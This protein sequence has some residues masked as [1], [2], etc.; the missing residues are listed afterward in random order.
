ARERPP[1][2]P[3]RDVCV[4]ATEPRHPYLIADTKARKCQETIGKAAGN[5]VKKRMKAVQ[6]CLA[7]LHNGKIAG[8]PDTVCRGASA[9]PTD[10]KAAAKLAKA[11]AKLRLLVGKKCTDSHLQLVDSCA[12]DVSGLQ[13]CL[14]EEHT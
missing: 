1:P 4:A 5:F 2:A 8:D 9:A 14:V 7:D 12:N 3:T 11:E 6:K 10:A 13:D